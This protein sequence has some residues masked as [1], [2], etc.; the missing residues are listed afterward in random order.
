MILMSMLH[1]TNTQHNYWILLDSLLLILL[2]SPVLYFYVYKPLNEQINI[3]KKLQ[4]QKNDLIDELQNALSEIKQLSGFIPIC[5]SCKNIR[6]DQ[7]YWK[8]VEQYIT[9]RSEAE[10]SHGICP[11]CTKKLYPDICDEDGNLI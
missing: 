10:F 9:E 6:D 4:Q 8:R 1:I 3:E 11:D 2:L 5:A 7:G